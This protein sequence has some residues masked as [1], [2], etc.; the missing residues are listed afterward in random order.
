MEKRRR[1]TKN[2]PYLCTECFKVFYIE[3]KTIYP[4]IYKQKAYCCNKCYTTAKRNDKKRK[5]LGLEI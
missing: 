3:N 4:F 1:K 2:T 5:L